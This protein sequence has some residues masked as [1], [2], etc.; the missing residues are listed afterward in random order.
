[1]R[2]FPKN[3]GAYV[4]DR[5]AILHTNKPNWSYWSTRLIYM[6]NLI[7]PLRRARRVNQFPSFICPN[8]TLDEKV[9][10]FG[11]FQISELTHIGQTGMNRSGLILTSKDRFDDSY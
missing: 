2:A 3:R 10:R 1:M 8:W 4:D 9:M 7:V 6:A 11:S 5:I